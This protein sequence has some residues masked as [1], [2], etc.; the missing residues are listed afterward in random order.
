MEGHGLRRYS[1]D[2]TLDAPSESDWELDQT[3]QDGD[4]DGRKENTPF[5]THRP[6]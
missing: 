6:L 1:V 5:L 4:R 3:N 2:T